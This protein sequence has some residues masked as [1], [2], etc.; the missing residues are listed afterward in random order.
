MPVFNDYSAE[1]K[2]LSTRKEPLSEKNFERFV[3][4]HSLEYVQ[5][6]LAGLMEYMNESIEITNTNA[7][8]QSSRKHIK[9]FLA[10]ENLFNSEAVQKILK[11]NTS[12]QSSEPS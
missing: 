8:Y 2:L 1:G 12:N 7:D 3:K 11:L 5:G 6:F 10:K 4:E 9:L